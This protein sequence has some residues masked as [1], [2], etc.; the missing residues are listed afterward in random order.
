MATRCI[1][2]ISSGADADTKGASGRSVPQKV[3]LDVLGEVA[4][5][6][7]GGAWGLASLCLAE[8]SEKG[9]RADRPIRLRKLARKIVDEIYFELMGM[10]AGRHN[11]VELGRGRNAELS[12]AAFEFLA[13]IAMSVVGSYES[14]S[15]DC[16]IGLSDHGWSSRRVPTRQHVAR[17]LERV[18]AVAVRERRWATVK[19]SISSLGKHGIRDPISYVR[20]ES[21]R[22]LFSLAASLRDINVELT[23]SCTA[24]LTH[25]SV[26]EMRYMDSAAFDV[27]QEAALRT[28]GRRR[29]FSVK[30]V[31][32]LSELGLR[33]R[34]S[35]V[36]AHVVR[37][38]ADLTAGLRREE[39]ELLLSC[40]TAFEELAAQDELVRDEIAEC[41]RNLG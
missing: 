23:D 39:P 19:Q 37:L 6:S 3:E 31:L 13:D 5:R 30:C 9:L 16:V 17:L 12:G 7:L 35:S 1:S 24:H 8:L 15:V 38:L 36:R 11:D 10:M 20:E 32:A 2:L 34:C 29:E 21:M 27:L 26:E 18:A 4:I 33:N 40:V 28:L 22:G 25:R 14:L 41:V